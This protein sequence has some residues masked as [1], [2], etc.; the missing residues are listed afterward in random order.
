MEIGNFLEG[1]KLQQKKGWK[2]KVEVRSIWGY[3][4]DLYNIDIQEHVAFH[5]YDFDGVQR[6]NYFG[7]GP[8]RRTEFEV[9]VGKPN[10]RPNST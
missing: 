2:C 8:I 3:F 4:D 5:M 7:V 6:G 10:Q 9:R 1:G